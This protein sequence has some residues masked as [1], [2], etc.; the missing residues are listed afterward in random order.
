MGSRETNKKTTVVIQV[1]DGDVWGQNNVIRGEEK[2]LDSRYILEEEL[3]GLDMGVMKREGSKRMEF[4][5]PQMENT[6][7]GACLEEDQKY[8]LD[9]LNERC[10]LDTKAEMWK[11]N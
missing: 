5:G 10:L 6:G 9:L 11:G 8:S 4:V 2:G 3:S 1:P 7:A